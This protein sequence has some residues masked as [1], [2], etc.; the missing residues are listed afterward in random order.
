M[1]LKLV[2]QAVQDMAV[3]NRQYGL[4]AMM[5]LVLLAPAAHP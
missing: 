2:Q 1:A 4:N 3:L 5:K